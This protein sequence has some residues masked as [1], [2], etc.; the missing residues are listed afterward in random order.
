MVTQRINQAVHNTDTAQDTQLSMGKDTISINTEQLYRNAYGE[1]MNE[2]AVN[3]YLSIQEDFRNIDECFDFLCEIAN[4]AGLNPPKSIADKKRAE[5][6]KIVNTPDYK[7]FMCLYNIFTTSNY[8]NAVE[9]IRLNGK[10]KEIARAVFLYYNARRNTDEE[11]RVVFYEEY[12]NIFGGD[13]ALAEDLFTRWEYNV[14]NGNNKYTEKYLELTRKCCENSLSFLGP[15]KSSILTAGNDEIRIAEYYLNLEKNLDNQ[16]TEKNLNQLI[17]SLGKTRTD[18]LCEYTKSCIINSILIPYIRATDEVADQT[19]REAWDKLNSCLIPVG[20]KNCPMMFSCI[21]EMWNIKASLGA[22][23]GADICFSALHTL[24]SVVKPEVSIIT[25]EQLDFALNG[26]GSAGAKVLC[27]Y[28]AINSAADTQKIVD[29]LSAIDY[30]SEC[31]YV[32]SMMRKCVD[33][34][35]ELNKVCKIQGHMQF[36]FSLRDYTKKYKDFDDIYQNTLKYIKEKNDR[37]RA[38]QRPAPISQRSSS[39][40]AK[41]D[42]QTIKSLKNK[43]LIPKD[44]KKSL[45]S[46]LGPIFPVQI[47]LGFVIMSLAFI[48]FDYE[49]PKIMSDLTFLWLV[50]GLFYPIFSFFYISSRVKK[51]NAG[52]KLRMI[53]IESLL[54]LGC[55]Y[56]N[57][58]ILLQSGVKDFPIPSVVFFLIVFISNIILKYKIKP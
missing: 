14:T 38:N 21:F 34:L 28:K 49:H 45:E 36:M 39:N 5:L 29:E 8:N 41:I 51:A 56:I 42:S 18:N 3:G 16:V 13:K 55:L 4:L 20:E 23:K 57:C 15:K 30:I 24:A 52:A 43:N 10:R 6:E 44:N 54:N 17:E 35:W 48:P 27:L 7:E 53:V 46:M 25:A 22:F 47:I 2:S 33:E 9:E 26:N 37:N 12:L 40:A 58:Q 31:P 19:S 1:I 32:K 11:K 50:L